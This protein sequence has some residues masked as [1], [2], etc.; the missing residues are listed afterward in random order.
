MAEPSL[1]DLG[2]WAARGTLGSVCAVLLRSTHQNLKTLEAVR[3]EAVVAATELRQEL[4]QRD[5]TISELQALW[6]ESQRKG[7]LANNRLK[8][9]EFEQVRLLEEIRRLRAP[10]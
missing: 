5:D 7:E 4:K 8:Q 3:K 9:F 10:D 2:S 1:L 6:A